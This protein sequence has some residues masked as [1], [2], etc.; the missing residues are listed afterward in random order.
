MNPVFKHAEKVKLFYPLP[1]SHN[2]FVLMGIKFSL[3]HCKI[4]L[5]KTK[6][7]LPKVIAIILLL[8]MASG[9]SYPQS[10]PFDIKENFFTAGKQRLIDTINKQTDVDYQIVVGRS[11]KPV[12][13]RINHPY[14]GSNEPVN[15]TLVFKNKH[16]QVNGLKYD[17]VNDRLIFYMQYKNH[18]AGF[19][20]LD[21]NFI[22]EFRIYN[23]T[24]RYYKGLKNRFGFN[25]KE[26]Y[27]QV[28]YD[29]KL[30]FL[31]RW[32]KSLSVN[33]ATE[34]NKYNENNRMYLLKNNKMLRIYNINSLLNKLNHN[35]R[36]IRTFIRDNNHHFNQS[37]VSAAFYI[38]DFYENQTE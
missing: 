28:V 24:F 9:F 8:F 29:G 17:I 18:T 34:K 10:I 12:V 36:D 27:Y 11:H 22:P 37:G 16:Y 25:L 2:L 7:S 15:G 6:I 26:G 38:L 4:S 14:F 5:L 19:I 1:P 30:K 32:E 23:S 20:S 31:V 13:S 33:D 21:H 35:K 3:L